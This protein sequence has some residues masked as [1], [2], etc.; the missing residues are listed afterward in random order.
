MIQLRH[1]VYAPLLLVLSLAGDGP[2]AA[3]KKGLSVIKADTALA[4]D[5]TL[6]SDE[7]EGRETGQPGCEKAA[8]FLVA[9]FQK[10]GLE[11]FGDV[12][13][14]KH[15]YLQAYPITA[16]TLGP[17]S[18]LTIEAASGKKRVLK[19][20][21]TV[22]GFLFGVPKNVDAV[23][24]VDGGTISLAEL[25]ADATPAASA[26]AGSRPSAAPIPLPEDAKGAFVLLRLKD[27]PQNAMQTI[28]RRVLSAIRNSGAEGLILAPEKDFAEYDA[29]FAQAK[30]FSGRGG[31]RAGKP[32]ANQQG[33]NQ[34]NGGTP[35]LLLANAAMADGLVG[36]K[37]SFS[38]EQQTVEKSAHNVVGLLRGSDPKLSQEYVIHSAH[39]DHEGIQ[40]GKIMH[41][42][43]DNA[44][45]TSCVLEI[46]KAYKST[47]A[48]RRSIIFLL[49]SGEEKGLWGS[50]WFSNNPPVEVTSL[51]GDI[52]TDMVGRTLL[53]GKEKPEYM[54]MT[55]SK[56]HQ[57]FNTLAQRALELGPEYGFPD[58]PSGDIY[59]QRS[60]HV[61]F[62]RKGIPVMFLCNGE[63]EDYHRPTD[64]SD[65][66]DGDKIARSAK[67]A[68][69]LGYEVAMSDD[70][71]KTFKA[72]NNEEEPASRGAGAESRRGGRRR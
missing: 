59:W 66:I 41:G 6:A 57:G 39:Y 26:P 24:I 61:N 21:D 19:Y 71:P 34:R 68:F 56:G 48:P 67:L 16:T 1:A 63:H 47:D 20:G 42:A 9:E 52:N 25:G 18:G 29:R 51:V 37:A 7:Y 53:N 4:H 40:G 44:S 31:L 11:P 2:S 10:L 17:N 54:M 60:D 69:H 22:A 5:V 27:L 43:D 38:T 55:P 12:V 65:K 32:S 15:T 23:P 35:Y 70:R 62:S 33:G 72:N 14:G 3:I 13:D 64:T 36:S 45:G 58:M 49:V 28:Q 8:K 30:S 50:A 46:V